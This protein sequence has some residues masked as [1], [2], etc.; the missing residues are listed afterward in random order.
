MKIFNTSSV[1]NGMELKEA[2]IGLGIFQLGIDSQ[3]KRNGRLCEDKIL[4]PGMNVKQFVISILGRIFWT[5]NPL[6]GRIFVYTEEY[7]MENGKGAAVLCDT[8]IPDMEY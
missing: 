2:E 4:S 8:K 5:Y 6:L 1:I 7:M 3:K